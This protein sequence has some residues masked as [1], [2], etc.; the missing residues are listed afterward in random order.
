MKRLIGAA[1]V[2]AVGVSIAVTSIGGA[3]STGDRTLTFVEKGGSFKFIDNPPKATKRHRAPS[4]GDFFVFET[5]L[6]DSTNARAGTLIAHCTVEPGA[7]QLSDCEGTAK[8]NDGTLAFSGLTGLNSLKNV[9][10]IVGGTGAY[11][12]ARGSVVSIARSHADNAPSDDTVH[13]LG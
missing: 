1:A 12:G 9:I 11:E 8:L 3:Q 7:G 4:P 2:L 10:A 5:P 6:Y 13:L